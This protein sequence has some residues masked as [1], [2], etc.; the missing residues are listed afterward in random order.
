MGHSIFINYRRNDTSSDAGRIHGILENKFGKDSVFLDIDDIEIGSKWKEVLE[1]A[2]GDA[3]VLLVLIGDQWLSKQASGQSRLFNEG[4]WVRL[5]IEAA[6]NKNMTVVPVLLKGAK[7][8]SSSELPPSILKLLDH[9]SVELRYNRWNDDVNH[10]LKKVCG[11]IYKK[12]RCILAFYWK[13]IASV[14]ASLCIGPLLFLKF[15]AP[16]DLPPAI[17]VPIILPPIDSFC[18]HF[19][20]PLAFKTLIF[21]IL[22][23]NNAAAKW[24]SL[25]DIELKDKC[26]PQIKTEI[27]YA[28]ENTKQISSSDKKD[29]ATKCGADLYIS[30]TELN[31][32]LRLDYGFTDDNFDQLLVNENLEL[33]AS[34]IAVNNFTTS[35]NQS[36]NE[37]ICLIVGMYNYKQKNY[38]A[39][40]DHL[41]SCH[42]QSNENVINGFIADSYYNLNQLD[43]SLVYI[44]YLEKSQSDSIAL[45]LKKAAIA[46]KAG[47][48]DK[49]IVAYSKV[50]DKEKSA[51]KKAKI[52]EKRGSQYEKIDDLKSA[53][54]DYKKSKVIKSNAILDNKIKA[55][56]QKIEA[57]LLEIKPNT[58]SQFSDKI[59]TSHVEAALQIGKI[60]VAAAM[61][62]NLEANGANTDSLKVFKLEVAMSKMN[63]GSLPAEVNEISPAMLEKFKR[64]K[65]KKALLKSN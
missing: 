55:V 34:S 3:K 60:D 43:S 19:K 11:L 36:Y 8:P 39:A 41:K 47:K 1:R 22:S 52:L 35:L 27:K 40:I 28:N 51:V 23:N 50:L 29:I 14:A 31:D 33:Q 4:D 53:K 9:Q 37:V 26:E 32:N 44:E 62:K 48:S 65:T 63:T 30:G 61:I 13:H 16:S 15:L 64:F 42:S 18:Y 10:L 58:S 24:Q 46:E 17:N 12:P 54:E 21:P 59:S 49:A 38:Q 5:E 7:L 2:G 6:L 57:N 25:I 20:K 45:L 56:N